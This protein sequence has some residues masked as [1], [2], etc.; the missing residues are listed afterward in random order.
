MQNE[1]CRIGQQPELPFWQVSSPWADAGRELPIWRG[2]STWAGD[3]AFR[4]LKPVTARGWKALKLPLTA[5][6]SAVFGP[7]AHRRR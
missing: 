3:V 1:E 2:S 5:H 4:N 6:P 7:A